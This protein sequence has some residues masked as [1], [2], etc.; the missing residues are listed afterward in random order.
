LICFKLRDR[1]GSKAIVEKSS[2]VGIVIGS[3][4]WAVDVVKNIMSTICIPEFVVPWHDPTLGYVGV[5]IGR[6]WCTR[7]FG[8]TANAG[9]GQRG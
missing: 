5:K 1:V 6:R 9:V 7:T 2:G 8:S 3:I 4:Y